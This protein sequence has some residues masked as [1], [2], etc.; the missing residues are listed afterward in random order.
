MSSPHFESAVV[1]V[2]VDFLLLCLCIY[3]CL[4]P[5]T[6]EVSI[7]LF[8]TFPPLFSWSHHLLFLP[9]L[10]FYAITSPLTGIFSLFLD[11]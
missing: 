1:A 9:E 8:R 2:N 3:F 5:G 11:Y 4:S 6:E 10:G 7:F